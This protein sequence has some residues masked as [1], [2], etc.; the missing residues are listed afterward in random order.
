M[1]YYRES[2]ISNPFRRLSY[3]ISFLAIFFFT[4]DRAGC[5]PN[6]YGPWT[7]RCENIDQLRDQGCM[8]YQELLLKKGGLPVLQFSV[9]VAPPHKK[10]I[11]LITLPLG[12]YLPAGV[13]L[14]IDQRSDVN[15]PIERCDPDGCHVLVTLENDTVETLKSGKNLEIMFRDGDKAPLTIPISLESFSEAF[16]QINIGP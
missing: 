10:P 8:M 4:S 13:S 7:I 5:S 14:T 15:F 1:I 11:V 9:G 16:S 12:I 2:R 3:V 6:E